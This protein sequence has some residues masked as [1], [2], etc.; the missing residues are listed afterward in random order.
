MKMFNCKPERI[1]IIFNNKTIF[2]GDY[3]ELFIE[4]LTPNCIK[5][6]RNILNNKVIYSLEILSYLMNDEILFISHSRK[7]FEKY[8]KKHKKE[9]V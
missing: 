4:F 6:Y 2:I 9:F 7:K 5:S 3:E 1:Y 8:L